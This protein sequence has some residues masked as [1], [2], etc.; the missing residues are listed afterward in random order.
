MNENF[1]TVQMISVE[2]Y[3]NDSCLP[4][5]PAGG[6]CVTRQFF[7]DDFFD[8]DPGYLQGFVA[9]YSDVVP[10]LMERIASAALVMCSQQQDTIRITQVIHCGFMIWKIAAATV[11]YLSQRKCFN[12]FFGHSEFISQLNGYYIP[13]GRKI[14]AEGRK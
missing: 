10:H 2:V 3:P 6:C 9:L 5:S 7:P 1:T 8:I 14:K 4:N 12:R 13:S 11:Q